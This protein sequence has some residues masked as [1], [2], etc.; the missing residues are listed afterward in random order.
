MNSRDVVRRLRAFQAGQPLVRGETRHFA[1]AGDDD[2]LIVAFLR[3]GGEARPWGIAFGH[4]NEEPRILT[5]PEPRNRDLVAEMAAGFAPAL[6]R[7]LRAPG[8]VDTPPAAW[9]HLRPLRQLSLPNP[10]HLEMLHHLAYA[11]TFTRYGGE[12]QP[13]LNALGRACGWLFREA[14]RPG[15]QHVLV[16]TEALRES[17]TFPA[18]D[19]RQVHLGY[20]LAWLET[21]GDRETRIQAAM[22]AERSAIATS[23]D[24]SI[25]RDEIERALDAWHNSA[26]DRDEDEMET[27]RQL[28]H[29]VLE[30]ELRRRHDLTRQ[31]IVRLRSDPRRINAGISTLVERGLKE[32]WFQYQRTELRIANGEE[33]VFVPS[34]E[35][36]R[37][38]PAAGAQYQK[39][40]ASA[41]LL[42]TLL[43]HDDSESFSDLVATGDAFNGVIESVRDE[44]R[45][46]TT[47]PVWRI[48]SPNQGP[49]RLR[50]N[51]WVSLLG[52]PDR[53]GEIRSI[54]DQLDGT[55]LFEVEILGLKTRPRG[56]RAS[57]V[58]P[59]ND[60]RHEGTTV[61]FVK[62]PAHGIAERIAQ[63][64][65]DRDVPGAWITHARPAGRR[66]TLPAD[67]AENLE[68]VESA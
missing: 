42:G 47:K 34:P 45:G 28:I 27:A 31:A 17:F 23:L 55:R 59:A 53:Y 66:A 20:L 12:A 35:T 21:R 54:D 51:S 4:P 8:F 3:M 64:I 6:L 58:L 39:H 14:Q 44:G 56:S 22:E 41:E 57:G 7:H 11:Y 10:S 61:E 33:G 67:V 2:L 52:L 16:T 29:Q 60:R 26:G 15:E 5:V 1:I 36:D 19:I 37:S 50:G 63:R 46:Q 62:K 24:P 32:Q 68:V 65:W 38:P 18:Q 40:V 25:E 48:R 30:R 49:L 9:E 13:L 43:A